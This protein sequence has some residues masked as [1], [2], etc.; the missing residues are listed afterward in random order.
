MGGWEGAT[1]TLSKL[2]RGDTAPPPLAST[3]AQRRVQS[4][5]RRELLRS[6]LYDWG[7]CVLVLYLP[8]G[9]GRP[10]GFGKDPLPLKAVANQRDQSKGRARNQNQWAG[11]GKAERKGS[12]SL[13]FL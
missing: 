2:T 3:S 10:F 11:A 13:T 6:R 12:S 8:L 4:L 5:P 9:Q 7:V 1:E